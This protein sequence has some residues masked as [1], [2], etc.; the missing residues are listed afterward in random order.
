MKL[1]ISPSTDPY[2]NLA[3][4][5]YIFDEMDR[6]HEYF[7]LWQNDN[8]I[9]VGVYQNTINEIKQDVVKERNIKVVRRLSGG[10]RCMRIWVI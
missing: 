2:F 1:I 9:I 7:M 5:Q 3:L 8:C 10:A 4:E 6:S